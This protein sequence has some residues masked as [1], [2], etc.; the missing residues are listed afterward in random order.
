VTEENDPPMTNVV[1][2]AS[3]AETDPATAG[4]QSRTEP[5]PDSVTAPNDARGFATP[6]PPDIEVKFPPT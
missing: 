3:I 2:E 6:L 1:D 4:A 5:T